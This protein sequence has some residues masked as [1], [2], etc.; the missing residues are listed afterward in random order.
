M[1]ENSIAF[2]FAC[3]LF[4]AVLCTL[5]GRT[6]R[7]LCHPIAV[8]SLAGALWGGIE[9]LFRVVS[10]D[11]DEV[12]YFLG[13]W[14]LGSFPRGV[15][16]EFRADLLGTLL[17]LVVVGVA[18]LVALYSKLPVSE[19][20]PEKEGPFY[21][22]FLLQVTGL[23]GICLTGDAF[24]LY[25]LIEVAALTGYGLIAMG[26]ARAAA[27]TFNYVILGTIGASFYLLGVGYVYAK[28]GTLNMVGIREVIESTKD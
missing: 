16:I 15:G 11:T 14:T 18:F 25:V 23:A 9:T 24:N 5:V 6:A 19:E 22:L 8:A 3:P 26:S 7:H 1:S 17:M 2:I 4:G 12:S 27:A 28:T 10:S 13:G 21:T 20:T